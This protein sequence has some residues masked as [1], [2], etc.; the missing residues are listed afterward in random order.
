VAS[1]GAAA[2]PVPGRFLRRKEDKVSP[3]RL[4]LGPAFLKVEHRKLRKDI[5]L[6]ALI[7]LYHI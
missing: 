4:R 1:S 5:I 3:M 6:L 7:Y 2:K